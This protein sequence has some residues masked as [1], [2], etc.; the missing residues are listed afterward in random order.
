MPPP[1]TLRGGVLRILLP[2]QLQPHSVAGPS[3]CPG[4]SCKAAA[5]LPAVVLCG[6]VEDLEQSRCRNTCQPPEICGKAVR[7]TL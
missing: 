5:G 3:G 1:S 7:Y 6:M 2:R 4:F